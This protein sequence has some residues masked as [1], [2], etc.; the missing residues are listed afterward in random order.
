MRNSR[1]R[2]GIMGNMSLS[3]DLNENTD[4]YR[5]FSGYW[6]LGALQD[7]EEKR[8]N[9]HRCSHKLKQW[10]DLSACI[11]CSVWIKSDVKVKDEGKK[12]ACQS[13]VGWNP[14]CDT[15]SLSLQLCAVEN[16]SLYS[17]Y[18]WIQFQKALILDRIIGS[19]GEVEKQS[20]RGDLH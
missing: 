19:T 8:K 9:T 3:W 11:R 13:R 17:L 5:E 20:E 1:N 4:I 14:D 18:L 16:K 10:W 2:L 12:V 7:K 15:T 6:M